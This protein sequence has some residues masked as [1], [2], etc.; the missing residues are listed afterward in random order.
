MKKNRPI[1]FR[2][3]PSRSGLPAIF[4]A[5]LPAV[6]LAGL[7]ADLPAAVKR[8]RELLLLE[9]RR[10]V[11]SCNDL[12]FQNQSNPTKIGVIKNPTN[13][14]YELEDEMVCEMELI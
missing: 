14:E 6:F 8:R 10:R 1:Q 4:V 2:I 11:G 9:R 13:M 5:G 12:P 3:G 7:S